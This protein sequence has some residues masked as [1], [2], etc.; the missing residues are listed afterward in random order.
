[1]SWSACCGRRSRLRGIPKHFDRRGPFAAS[2]RNGSRQSRRAPAREG[3][4]QTPLAALV[5][6]TPPIARIPGPDRDPVQRQAW[7]IA[8]V[9]TCSTICLTARPIGC[10]SGASPPTR[11]IIAASSTST[12]LAALSMEREEVFDDT[13]KL[14][15]RL[16]ADGAVDGL[17]IDHR[18]RPVRSATIPPAPAAALCPKPGKSRSQSDSTP[19]A[20]D[21][22][23]SSKPLRDKIAEAVTRRP[24]WPVVAAAVRGRRKNPRGRR[25]VAARIGPVHGT[26]GY[27]FLNQVNGLFVDT[28]TPQA[29]TRL[30]QDWIAGRYAFCGAGLSEE[31]C[32]SSR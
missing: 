4:H 32:S 10:R 6:A 27:D 19:Q 3:S 13:H 7:R 28:A 20:S 11:S 12:N 22:D 26:S 9:S 30:Y 21:W 24:A 29:F 18:G 17:R 5:Q 31:D 1:M 23:A 25:S 15:L 14:V 8:R 16:L 2:F